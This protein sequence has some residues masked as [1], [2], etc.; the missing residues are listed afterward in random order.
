MA[1]SDTGWIA[2]VALCPRRRYLHE[3]GAELRPRACAGETD[4]GGCSDTVARKPCLKF[5]IGGEATPSEVDVT[6][7]CAGERYRARHQPA[8]I[9][10]IHADQRTCL[11]RWVL[12]V[13]GL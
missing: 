8:V 9:T 4:S 11:P 3:S 1:W 5:L 7:S 6:T 13:D 10:P 12:H 2:V